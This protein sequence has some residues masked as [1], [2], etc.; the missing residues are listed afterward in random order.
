MHF[1]IESLRTHVKRAHCPDGDVDTYID[2]RGQFETRA[3]MYD[4]EICSES[5]KRNFFSISG[6]LSVKHRGIAMKVG[7]LCQLKSSQI[8]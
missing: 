1:Y 8:F 3:V 6:H 2:E 4:C 7:H 5:I